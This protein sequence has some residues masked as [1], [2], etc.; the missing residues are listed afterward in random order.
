M[1]ISW[2]RKLMAVGAGAVLLTACARASRVGRDERASSRRGERASSPGKRRRQ[3]HGGV[4]H[5]EALDL[6]RGDVDPPALDHVHLPGDEVEVALV[7]EEPDADGDASHLEC[8]RADDRVGDVLDRLRACVEERCTR[9][10][11]DRGD[12]RGRKPQ[13]NSDNAPCVVAR[14]DYEPAFILM[15]DQG[16]QSSV[17][18]TLLDKALTKLQE[19]GG[20]STTETIEGQEITVV[21]EGD[22]QKQEERAE[23]LRS[24]VDA[25]RKRRDIQERVVRDELGYVKPGDVVVRF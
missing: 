21:R 19:D 22:N 20:E 15:I 5:Q 7:V 25:L 17:A 10:P 11:G 12:A 23:Q 18:K 9:L 14:Q 3:A 16:D 6:E 13:V 2:I 24:E 8:I 4:L 1:T